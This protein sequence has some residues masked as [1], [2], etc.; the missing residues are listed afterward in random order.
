MHTFVEESTSGGTPD[1]RLPFRYYC[2]WETEASVQAWVEARG[3]A[4]ETG[5]TMENTM[6]FAHRCNFV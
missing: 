4:E 6:S 1:A 5:E 3:F 2:I